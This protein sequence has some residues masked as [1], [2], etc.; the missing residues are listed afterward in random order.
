MKRNIFVLLIILLLIPAARGDAQNEISAIDSMTIDL[1]PDY[2]RASVLVLLTGLLPDDTRFPAI[3]TVPL[4]KNAQLNAVARIDGRDGIMKDD[5]A[6]I[7]GPSDMLMFITPDLQFRVEYYI[8]Y[9]V[10]GNQRLFDYAW[11][12]DIAVSNLQLKIQQPKAATSFDVKPAAID[13]VTDGDGLTYH[14]FPPRAVLAGQSFSVHLEY[15]M[16]TP[17]LS[18]NT[19]PR[20]RAESQVPGELSR[21]A[22]GSRANWAILVI[23]VGG[24]LIII[25]VVWLIASRRNQ[26][27]THEPY[28]QKPQ[29]QSRAKFCHDCGE[30]VD[31]AD[32]WCGQCGTN[33]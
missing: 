25:G 24:L 9:T 33:L 13:I 8:P 23:I 7:P 16:T 3:V 2:D 14:A 6:S 11:L 4:P 5:I 27:D 15:E 10:N 22:T 30:P 18:A 31:K 28:S 32:K 19:L 26:M 17:Q 29:K 20:A 1:W 21:S 12:A